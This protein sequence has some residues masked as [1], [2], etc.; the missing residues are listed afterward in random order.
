MTLLIVALA[1]L[2]QILAL[3]F[4]FTAVRWVWAKVGATA[5]PEGAPLRAGWRGVGAG[6]LPGA[7]GCASGRAM[8]P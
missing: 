5:R 7:H 8:H 1:F 4:G 6:A 3:A 2:A